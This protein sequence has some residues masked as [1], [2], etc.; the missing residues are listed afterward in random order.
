[1]EVSL[2]LYEYSLVFKPEM[3]VKIAMNIKQNQIQVLLSNIRRLYWVSND[4]FREKV[5]FFNKGIYLVKKYDNNINVS[6]FPLVVPEF[7]RCHF[8]ASSLMFLLFVLRC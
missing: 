1:M 4:T 6:I 8:K 3:Y 7:C 5:P 2:N